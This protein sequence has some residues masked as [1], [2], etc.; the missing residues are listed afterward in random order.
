MRKSILPFITL[1][2]FTLFISACNVEQIKIDAATKALDQAEA[3]MNELT[4]DQWLDLEITI[5]ELEH[6]LSI[7]KRHY[8]AE[9]IKE[10]RKLQGRYAALMLK[11]GFQDTKD[12]IRD[13][14][15]QLEGFIE[16][17]SQDTIKRPSNK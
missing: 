11:K 4:D 3:G 15:S 5:E 13:F 9:Q 1:T 12:I 6:D 10:I 16:G 2:L 17:I 14:G 7:N 8:T